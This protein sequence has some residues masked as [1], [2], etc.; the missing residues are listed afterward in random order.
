MEPTAGRAVKVDSDRNVREV[1]N[2][3]ISLD[4]VR[5]TAILLVLLHHLLWAKSESPNL[6]LSL[7]LRARGAGW[8]GVD[9]FFALSGFLITGILYGS[10]RDRRFFWNFYARRILRI[11]PLYYSVVVVLATI[12][13]LHGMAPDLRVVGIVAAYLQNTPLYL[14][15]SQNTVAFQ[16]TGHLWSLAVEEQFYLVWPVVVFLVKD[17]RK[18]M[19]IAACQVLL[20]P[21]LRVVLLTHGTSFAEVYRFTICRADSL[22][23]GA[24]LA[25]A[26]RG[27]MRDRVFRAAVPCFWIALVVCCGI[28][29]TTGNFDWEINYSVNSFGYSAVALASAAIIAMA[30]QAGTIVASIMRLHWLRF[31]GR[32]SYGLY[33]YHVIVDQ[34][35]SQALASQ[36]HSSGLYRIVRFFLAM[37]LS[38]LISV[39]SFNYF[40]KPFLSMKRFFNYDREPRTGPTTQKL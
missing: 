36:I 19:W 16:Y 10:L 33:I 13:F 24:W 37:G 30:L 38:I 9:L 31:L 2:H 4:G 29:T 8:V 21:I 15:H 26:V 11:F 12:F 6:A 5:G 22:L 14:E 25:L 27:P 35:A 1:L 20:S 40:E 18:L 28:A 7:I 3:V 17:R 32:Y 23:A 34:I 39:V